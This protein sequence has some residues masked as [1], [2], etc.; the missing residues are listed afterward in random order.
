MGKHLYLDAETE[1]MQTEILKLFP[2]FNFSKMY[3]L[4][5]EEILGK[6]LSNS[7]FTLKMIEEGRQKVQEGKNQ[8]AHYE[9]LNKEVVKQTQDIKN[10]ERLEQKEKEAKRK[11]KIQSIIKAIQEFYDIKDLDKVTQLA[12]EFEETRDKWQSIFQFMKSEGY[13]D[14]LPEKEAKKDDFHRK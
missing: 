7:E 14:N 13:E 1:R 12:E 8:I 10:L 5:M 6:T 2:H 3:K 4:R 11:K 9:K